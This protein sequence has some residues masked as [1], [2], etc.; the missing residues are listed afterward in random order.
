[1]DQWLSSPAASGL[2]LLARIGIGSILTVSG[3]FKIRAGHLRFRNVVA[4]YALLPS[5]AISPVSRVVPGLEIAIGASM[6]LGL[7]WPHPAMAASSLL[8]VFALALA[9][10]ILRGRRDLACGCFG[11]E[12]LRPLS[13][14]TVAGRVLLV[15]ASL[16]AVYAPTSW[17][18]EAFAYALVFGLAWAGAWILLQALS[19]MT[20]EW[21][22]GREVSQ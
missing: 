13:W 15:S 22:R 18:V 7:L 3:L 8:A 17:T 4:A 12:S 6:L 20:P 14:R 16:L 19:V 5:W 1:M 11:K 9:I 10:N 21:R 2:T